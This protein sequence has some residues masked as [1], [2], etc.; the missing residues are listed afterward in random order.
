VQKTKEIREKNSLKGN[1][2][3]SPPPGELLGKRVDIG[4]EIHYTKEM[5]EGKGDTVKRE[6]E[7]L[8]SAI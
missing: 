1:T 7:E 4:H 5:R 3:R 8:Q 2:A 6:E